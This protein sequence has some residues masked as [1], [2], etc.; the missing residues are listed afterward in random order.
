MRTQVNWSATRGSKDSTANC[1]SSILNSSTHMADVR[2]A[3]HLPYLLLLPSGEYP[4][5]GV[6]SS[7]YVHETLA[8]AIEEASEA[9]T[10]ASIGFAAEEGGDPET[11][12][13]IRHQQADRLLRRPN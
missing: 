4:V 3:V 8:P 7:V 11:L 5:P 2:V 1:E 6:G 12:A 13:R 10:V 9:K